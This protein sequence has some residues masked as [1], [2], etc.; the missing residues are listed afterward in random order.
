MTKQQIIDTALFYADHIRRT[1]GKLAIYGDP[2]SRQV[3][4]EHLADEMLRWPGHKAWDS[5]KQYF[6]NLKKE[7]FYKLLV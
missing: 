3:K 5:I 6:D 1:D 7:G 2:L 4:A